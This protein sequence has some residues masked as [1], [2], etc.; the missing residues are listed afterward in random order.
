M[1]GKNA[2]VI[3]SGLGGLSAAISRKQSGCD[4]ELFKSD[5]RDK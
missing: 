1:S 2:I 5:A 3:G 4:I